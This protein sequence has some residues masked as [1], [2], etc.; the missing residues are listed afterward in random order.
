MSP[1][2]PLPELPQ[3]RERIN[4][5]DSELLRLFAERMELSRDVARTKAISGAA[6]FD[7]L[8]ED[9]IAAAAREQ[10]K[11]DDGIR[12]EKLLRSL[13]RLSRGVQYDLLLPHD[14]NFSLGDQIK[15][16]P[17]QF[18]PI[19]RLIHQGTASS[20]S[21]LAC[22]RLFPDLKA[23]PVQTFEEAC[24]QVKSGEADAAVLPIENSTAGTI[25]D[26]YALVQHYGLYF[27]RTYDLPIHHHLLGLPGSTRG[28][29]KRV[30][31][32]PQA[33]AQCSNTIRQQGWTPVES[34]NTA[35]AAQTT[36]ESGDLGLAAIA[37]LEAAAASHL[38][39]LDDQISNLK[40]NT[41]RFVVIGRELIIDPQA[42]RLSLILK[43]S[44]ASG[45]L[46]ATLAMFADRNLVLSKIHSRPNPEEPWSY[47]FDLDVDCS[48]RDPQALATLY[49]LSREMSYLQLLGWYTTN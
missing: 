36:A 22:T 17:A 21:A 31:S 10:I 4:A 43:T 8:R 27:W 15:S 13:M 12:A 29:I 23:I 32:H 41:T 3:L 48:A 35:F 16:A 44:H 9:Q 46:A 47:L 34:L 40:E 5:I 14:K 24:L 18:P 11:G 49:Q 45:A 7:P 42:T 2:K 25:V 37:S 1:D 26:V 38:I 6:V 19:K 20:Y 39:V 28:Q 33:L 30:I